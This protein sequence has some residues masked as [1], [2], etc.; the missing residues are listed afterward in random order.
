MVEE[1]NFL[2]KMK[3][4]RLAVCTRSFAPSSPSGKPHG[5]H[6]TFARL[7]ALVDTLIK[8]LASSFFSF[9]VP[10]GSSRHGSTSHE[11]ARSAMRRSIGVPHPILVD[12]L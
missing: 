10:G 6:N 7:R 8:F 12:P 4:A 2:R 9:D 5:S 3:L 11:R 1:G